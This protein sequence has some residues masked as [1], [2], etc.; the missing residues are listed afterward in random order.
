M[1][2]ACCAQALEKAASQLDMTSERKPWVELLQAVHDDP[3]IKA[4]IGNKTVAQLRSRWR[5]THPAKASPDDL[6]LDS[7]TMHSRPARNTLG[8]CF[9]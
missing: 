3:L 8:R 6:A 5:V 9:V 2:L 7:G 1:T 4:E